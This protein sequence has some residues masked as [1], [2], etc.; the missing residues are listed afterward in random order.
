MIVNDVAGNM[1]HLSFLA[2]VIAVE[3]LGYHEQLQKNIFISLIFTIQ[4]EHFQNKLADIL[5]YLFYYDKQ[6]N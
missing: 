6:L 2:K 1:R 4:Y 5:V 3:R